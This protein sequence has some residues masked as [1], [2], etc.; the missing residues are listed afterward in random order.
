MPKTCWANGMAITGYLLFF[1]GYQR[2]L[3][4]LAR[5]VCGLLNTV[6]HFWVEV[7]AGLGIFF[8]IVSKLPWIQ[9]WASAVQSQGLGHRQSLWGQNP[10]AHSTTRDKVNASDGGVNPPGWATRQ[11]KNHNPRCPHFQLARMA[12]ISVGV[13]K[14]R[15][16]SDH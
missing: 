1:K 4:K 9:F 3:K 2:L 14:N 7:V 16:D 15:S 5:K 10:G 11:N 8:L 6:L 12:L 13:N